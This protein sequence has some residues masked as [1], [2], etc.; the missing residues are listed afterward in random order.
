MPFPVGALREFSKEKRPS[1][2]LAVSA[3]R[4][5]FV[6]MFLAQV[7]VALLVV[8]L[9]LL[10]GGSRPS[11]GSALG[12]VLAGLAFVQCLLG[13]A[14]P[15][16]V[17]RPGSKGSALSATLLAGVLLATPSWFLMLALVTGQR[18]LPL[19]LLLATALGAYGLGF[20]LAGRIG[21]RVAA[22][23]ERAQQ[24]QPD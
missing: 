2:Q 21:T 8:T 4:F 23:A 22:V 14:L 24:P 6:T 10:L 1:R 17:A 16:A 12:P 15:D 13:F 7:G 3:L 5:T 20:G 18:L 9:I 11:G 19:M